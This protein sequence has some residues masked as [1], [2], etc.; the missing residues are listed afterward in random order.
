MEL[1]CFST[2]TFSLLTDSRQSLTWDFSPS[3]DGSENVKI[4]RERASLWGKFNGEVENLT[5]NK[6]KGRRES[7]RERKGGKG[8][9]NCS[10]RSIQQLAPTI[11]IILN[12]YV[13]HADQ[14]DIVPTCERSSISKRTKYQNHCQFFRITFIH[15]KS[16]TTYGDSRINNK[17][18]CIFNFS[19]FH[20]DSYHL[21]HHLIAINHQIFVFRLHTICGSES[22]SASIHCPNTSVM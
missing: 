18:V 6:R 22:A 3:P 11:A 14:S 2:A 1:N 8:I 21:M 4:S 20:H 19:Y 13:E 9:G 16:A 7:K 5:P 15:H 10:P 17:L 12:I